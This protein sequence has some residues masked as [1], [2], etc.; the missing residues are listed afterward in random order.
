[1]PE[2]RVV[3]MEWNRRYLSVLGV[4]NNQLYELRLQ[5]PENVFVEEENDLRK[6]MASFR[7]NKLSA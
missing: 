7:V 1:M 6:V 5:V 3:R 4:E 2:D